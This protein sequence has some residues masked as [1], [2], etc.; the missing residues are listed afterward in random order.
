MKKV[1]LSQSEFNNSMVK[2]YEE[3]YIKILEEKWNSLLGYEK[4]FVLEFLKVVYP[5]N[6]TLINEAKW[7]NTLGDL[8]GIV[9]PTG[10]V[11]IANGISYWKQGDKLFALLS[12]IGVIPIIGDFFGKGVMEAV[13]AGGTGTKAFKA[14][15]LAGDASK[16]AE[17]AKAAGGP[18][19]TMVKSSST[20]GSKLI[21]F[22]RA[23]I[24]KIPILG[25][26]FIKLLEEYILIFTK[27]GK[28][29]RAGSD[30]AKKLMAKGSAL[31]SLEKTQ[32]KNALK[33]SKEFRGFRGYKGETQGM[34]EKLRGGVPKLFGNAATRSLMGRTKW[35]LGLLDFLGIGNFV[36]PDELQQKYM[37]LESKI[38]EYNKTEKAEKLAKDDFFDFGGEGEKNLQ[39]QTDNQ[40]TDKKE[41]SG[42]P[43]G[44]LT[45]LLGGGTGNIASNILKLV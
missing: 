10:I 27:A 35:Y 39:T 38:S 8:V 30:I 2:I 17:T 23:T 16:I 6:K 31:S 9:D 13:K 36:G 5:E 37:D 20:W 3:E 12:F 42:D 32:L 29:M 22:L 45:S 33:A 40:Q 41:T 11:D 34:W 26:G 1:I 19:A 43:L 25:T 24:G 4:I 18:I 14:A 21:N 44:I 15:A 7:Y 28:E